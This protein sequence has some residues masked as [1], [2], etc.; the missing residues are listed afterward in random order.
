[1]PGLEVR[2]ATRFLSRRRRGSGAVATENVVFDKALTTI[3]EQSTQ[4]TVTNGTS[5]QLTL[6]YGYRS[7]TAS[8]S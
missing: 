7:G 5:T 6:N 8:S 4:I 2:A 3:R 1:V